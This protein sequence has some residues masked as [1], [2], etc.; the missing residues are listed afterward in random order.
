MALRFPGPHSPAWVLAE[1]AASAAFSLVSLLVIGR[2]IGPHEAGVGAVA[3][4]AFLLLD[5]FGASLFPD[6][7]VQRAG[8]SER[9]LR[10]ALT[11]STLVGLAAALVLAG[12]A[13]LL[14]AGTGGGGALVSLLLALAPLL[15]ASAFSGAASGFAMREQRYRLLA[16][17]V[18]VAQPIALAA[19]LA[20]A[21]GGLGAWA[22][23]VN[24][25]V[26][27]ALVF[28]L[29]LAAGRLPLRPALD[30]A[31]LAE[32]WP[33][34]GPQIS[35]VVLIVGKY[36][37]FVLALGLLLG[38]AA[39]AHA[40]VAFR[41][42]DAALFVVW[43]A[44]ARIAMPRLCALQNDREALA[45][46]YGD[47]AQLPALVG[48]PIAL[49]VA[50]VADDLV[51]ALLGPAWAGTAEAARVVALA[52]CVTFL[53][54][55]QFSLFVALGRA[56]LNT[57]AAAANLAV[58]LLALLALRP[59]TAAGAALAWSAQSLLVTPVFAVVVLRLLGKSPLWLLRRAA[60]GVLAGSAMAAAV[61]LAQGA[62]AEAAPLARLLAA[63]AV[64]AAV[65]AAV[66]WLALGRRLP[67][68]LAQRGGGEPPD[69]AARAA[70]GGA[71]PAGS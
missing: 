42:V 55:D 60:P 22:I 10:S 16:L 52:A 65:F 48:L 15:P 66:A 46:C 70:A 14:A 58:P 45:R 63:V 3:I 23:V 62:M 8:L 25:A 68:A 18:L 56:R 24:Q 30:R 31:A 49:G 36:R 7:L 13:P 11:A 21:A 53:H 41:M 6:A 19:G 35:A 47:T 34:A 39:L 69:G 67:P 37:I 40:H 2:V 9:H 26:A 71:V 64:G 27:T 33:V 28:L 29:F 43:G 38:E 32:L 50:L 4:A 51:A 1:T 57:L 44:M 20:A 59:Q 54:G 12:A 17:R 61:L 5:V